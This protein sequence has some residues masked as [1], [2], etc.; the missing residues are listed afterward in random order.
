MVYVI[1][2]VLRYSKNCIGGYHSFPNITYIVVHLNI[3]SLLQGNDF[4]QCKCFEQKKILEIKKQN[5]FMT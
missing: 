3:S 1:C 2:L 5:T 4:F